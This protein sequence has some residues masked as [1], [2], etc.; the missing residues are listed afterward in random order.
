MTLTDSSH[1]TGEGSCRIKEA[2]TSAARRSGLASA[3]LISGTVKS[4]HAAAAT[5]RARRSA[6][7]RISG[8]WTG[9]LTGSGIAFRLPLALASSIARSTAAFSPAITTCPGPLK[10][11]GATTPTA[12]ASRQASRTASPV[13]PRIA[14]T[15]PLPGGTASAIYRPRFC[16][17]E[18]AVLKE[19]PPAATSA[20]Y[21]PRL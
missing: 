6:A 12:D 15:N 7:V 5:S 17:S 10:F 1:K 16:T 9:T 14:A 20:E 3:L 11:A 19:S 4:D 18:T 13:R 8:V 2:C 21:S